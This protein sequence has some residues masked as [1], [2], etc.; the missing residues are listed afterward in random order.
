MAGRLGAKAALVTLLALATT[1]WGIALTADD[2]D[3]SLLMQTGVS[4]PAVQ[5]GHRRTGP[6]AVPDMQCYDCDDMEEEDGAS[7]MQSSL[8]ASLRAEELETD[9]ASLMSFGAAVPGGRP[10]ATT[11]RPRAAR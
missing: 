11:R 4:D 10:I 1:C 5:K 9:E 6:T 3:E 2:Y 8:S 7:L